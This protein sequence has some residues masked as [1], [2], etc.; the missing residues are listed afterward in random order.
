M[1]AWML[2]DATEPTTVGLVKE[3]SALAQASW[4]LRAIPGLT[5]SSL[6]SPACGRIGGSLVRGHRGQAMWRPPRSQSGRR[7]QSRRPWAWDGRVSYGA[8]SIPCGEP[9]L[10]G[11][12]CAVPA[13]WGTFGY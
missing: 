12:T 8:V 11:L 7:F 1:R 9:C 5:G 2:G 3:K 13:S 10:R 4:E 6:Q